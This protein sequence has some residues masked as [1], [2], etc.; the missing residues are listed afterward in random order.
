MSLTA[1]CTRCH[2]R[3]AS[4]AIGISGDVTGLTIKNMSETCPRCGGRAH[5]RDGVYDFTAS[6]ITSFRSLDR[7]GLI[8][9]RDLAQQVQK[10]RVQPEIAQM[11]ARSAG[12]AAD[13]VFRTA[14]AWGVPSLL[15]ALIT[16][17]LQIS[18]DA[19]DADRADRMEALFR[20][21][22]A[23]Q[24][25]MVEALNR[26]NG[27]PATP[28]PPTH[29]PQTPPSS[30]SKT[31]GC[32]GSDRASRRRAWKEAKKTSGAPPSKFRP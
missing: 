24:T 28:A 2:L 19:A 26:I 4:R 3:F 17:W 7:N 31:S 30:Q 22:L 12:P 16:L 20:E 29:S 23:T 15:V 8:T 6:V 1:Q 21:Q 5:V 32:E 10:G 9:L 11:Q 18:G 14:M 27:L 13:D 25:Q